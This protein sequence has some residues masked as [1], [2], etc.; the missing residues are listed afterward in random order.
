MTAATTFL[1]RLKEATKPDH[2]ATEQTVDLGSRAKTPEGYRALLGRFLG[3]YESAEARLAPVLGEMAGLNFADRRKTELIK[4]DLRVLGFDD[5]AIDAL[6]RYM[7]LERLSD[8]PTALG[9]MY[10]L[11]GATLGGQY[12]SK[13]I[14][15]ILDVRPGEGC[16]FFNS[17]GDNVGPMWKAFKD[18]L[19]T[20]AE[21]DLD[22]TTLIASARDTFRHFNEWFLSFPK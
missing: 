20:S 17:Y 19:S 8:I 6:P 12:V 3:F 22:Q 18:I 9:S 1:S 5:A 13:H 14:Q 2:E 10:V 15:S 16:S 4:A 7:G 21:S 11:E